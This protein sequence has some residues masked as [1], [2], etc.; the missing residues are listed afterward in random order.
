MKSYDL[1]VYGTGDE[2]HRCRC[3][4]ADSVGKGVTPGDSVAAVTGNEPWLSEATGRAELIEPR[5][6]C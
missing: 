4:E 5:L 3:G 1:I 6:K 2:V